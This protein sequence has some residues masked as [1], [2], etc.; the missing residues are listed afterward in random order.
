L[1]DAEVWL[2]DEPFTALDDAAKERLCNHLE[3]HAKNGGSA[4]VATH[5]RLD[6]NK[7]V[8]REMMMS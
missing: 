4:V 2:L 5:E 3:R 1:T 8:L 7:S 6:I